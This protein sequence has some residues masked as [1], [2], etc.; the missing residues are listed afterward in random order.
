MAIGPDANFSVGD[1]VA[2]VLR[3]GG[4]SRFAVA[5]NLV[6]IDSNE[7]VHHVC[8]ILSTYVAAFQM[9]HIGESNNGPIRY[10]YDYLK[11]KVVFVNGG[12]SGFGQAVIHLANVFGAK[13]VY[14]TSRPKDY[15][16]L[17]DL[18]SIPLPLGS[19]NEMENLVGAI[20]LVIDMTIYSSNDNNIFNHLSTMRKATTGRLVFNVH[21]DIAKNGRHGVRTPLELIQLRSKF[22]LLSNVYVCDHLDPSLRRKFFKVR[23]ILVCV[24]IFNLLLL[25]RS[26][27][28]SSAHQCRMISLT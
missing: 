28:S 3:R 24:V 19:V 12:M 2:A 23:N 18:G 27:L 17:R 5:S 6:K 22:L 20:D 10:D 7:N 9:L 11:G 13:R 14:A 21:G 25:Q 16:H 26:K 8:G 4:N 1:K 15:D